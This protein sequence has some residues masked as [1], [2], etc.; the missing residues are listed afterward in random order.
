MSTP[1][2]PLELAGRGLWIFPVDHPELAVCAGVKT[3]THD[4]LKCTDRG[5]H[6]ANKWGTGATK[7]PANIATMFSGNPRNVGIHCGKSGLLVADEDAE[8]EF[9]RF[10]DDH[11]VTI[12]VTYTVT[13]AKGKHWYFRDTENGRLGNHEGAF[14]DYA[15]NIRSGEGFV[16]GP[17]S[18]HA[19]GVVYTENGVREIAELPAWMVRAIDKGK[20]R[21]KND[22]GQ[23]EGFT[24]PNP[25]PFRNRDNVFIA[26]AGHLLAL[27]VPRWEAELLMKAAWGT[28]ENSPTD[29]YPLEQA[30]EKLDRYEP[31]RSP[32]YEKRFKN[33]QEPDDGQDPTKIDARYL[34]LRGQLLDIDG[35][36]NITPPEPLV[37]DWMFKNTLVWFSGAPGHAKSFGAVDVAC[38]VATGTPWHGHQV[39]QGPVLYLIAEG[40]AG[41]SQRVDAWATANDTKVTGIT[42]LPV[43]VQIGKPDTVDVAAFTMLLK[44]IRPALAI[45]DTQARV[46]VGS[47]ENSSKDMGMF[48]D[49]LETLRA[50]TE[51]TIL[52]VHHTPR[53]GENLRGSTALEGAASTIIH[54]AKDGDEVELT[55]KKQKDA[56]EQPKMKL[57]LADTGE[58]AALFSDAPRST[59]VGPNEQR[60]LD[61]LA[62]YRDRECPATELKEAVNIGGSFHRARNKLLNQ[63]RILLRVDGRSKLYRLADPDA[64]A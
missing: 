41:L 39:A 38:C 21:P 47:E 8:G 59:S 15:I 22:Q 44:D 40:A 31:G 53:N 34:A 20:E 16:V 56:P 54:F 60:I 30:L 5:K 10:C 25:I 4:P 37:A 48:V 24:L 58:S 62:D 33:G 12:P 57:T 23:Y 52:T 26:Y 32:G 46:T 35:L 49:V 9:Q 51:A 45:I 7:A 27:D 3:S 61:V 17:G 64:N 13:T 43:P 11:K 63:G 55:N 2:T 14:S 6:P 1:P 19:T 50:V 36:R 18:T 28:A 42:F 29:Y